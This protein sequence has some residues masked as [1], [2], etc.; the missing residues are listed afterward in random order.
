MSLLSAG[1]KADIRAAIKTVTDT[2]FVTPVTYH[3]KGES[4][5]RFNEDRGDQANTDYVMS[6]LVEYVADKTDRVTETT[7]GALDA[8]D[9]KI[10]MNLADLKV[11]GLV[12]SSNLCIGNVAKDYFTTNGELY[13]V[14]FIG[15]DGPL[16]QQNVLVIMYGERQE[17][18]S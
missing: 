10:S 17:H 2:F 3:L 4:I 8:A 11:L 9:I 1:Q 12:N 7:H 13:K 14:G 6:A 16:D 5:D 18:K 15:F